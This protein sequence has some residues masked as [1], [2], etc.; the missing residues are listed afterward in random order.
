M[1][2]GLQI[3]VIEEILYVDFICNRRDFIKKYSTI[4]CRFYM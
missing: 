1:F 3:F 4:I 2:K